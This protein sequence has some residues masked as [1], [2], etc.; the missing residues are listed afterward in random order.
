MI[1]FIAAKTDIPYTKWLKELNNDPEICLARQSVLASDK[2]A[3]PPWLRKQYDDLSVKVGLLFNKEQ[4]LVPASLKEGVLQVLHGDHAGQTYMLEFAGN[5]T[6]KTKQIDVQEKASNCLICFTG[7][8]NLKPV[9]ANNKVNSDD[10]TSDK[11]REKLQMD[12]AGPFF[13]KAGHKKIVLLAVDG[14]SRW[15]SAKL[16]KGCRTR[17]VLKFLDQFC[18][19]NGQQKVIKSD[20]G[21]AFTS[22]EFQKI[23]KSKGTRNEFSTPYHHIPIGLVKR[24][25][26]LSRITWRHSQLKTKRWS[27]Q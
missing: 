10:P 15:L 14:F 17:D 23:F 19:D 26:K 11:P 20:M 18:L 6:W 3:L 16:T 7:G 13:D 24:H 9:L 12:F 21:P 27:W 1:Q 2:H 8:K 25:I 5:L 22:K 4:L